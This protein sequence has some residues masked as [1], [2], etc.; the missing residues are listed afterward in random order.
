MKKLFLGFIVMS[1]FCSCEK[2]NKEK[3]LELKDENGMTSIKFKN[4]ALL[5][6]EG[7]DGELDVIFYDFSSK[8]TFT[9]LRKKEGAAAFYENGTYDDKIMMTD[10]NGDMFPD[11]VSGAKSGL[12]SLNGSLEPF[13]KKKKENQIN[14]KELI[15]EQMELIGK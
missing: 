15:K 3:D 7:K 4:A 5:F 9:Y 12:F 2:R 6:R 13:G 11:V 8:N 10:T 14:L 1:F